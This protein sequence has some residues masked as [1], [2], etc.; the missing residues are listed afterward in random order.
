MCNVCIII[1]ENINVILILLL[2]MCINIINVCN[3]NIIISII[4]VY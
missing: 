2:I 1:N 3:D 4:N